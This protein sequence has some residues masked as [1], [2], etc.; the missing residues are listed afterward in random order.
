[1]HVPQKKDKACDGNLWKA[2]K[3]CINLE[4][5]MMVVSKNTLANTY[6]FLMTF[7]S[8]RKLQWYEKYHS[9]LPMIGKSKRQALSKIKDRVWQKFQEWKEK[10]LS[11]GGKEI[12]LKDVTLSIFTY[13]MSCFKLPDSLCANLERLWL[14]FSGD[15]KTM[16]EKFTRLVGKGC[17]SL[18]FM[19]ES[20]SSL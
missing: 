16:K 12:I 5:R 3:Q 4:K 18:S 7:W 20:V 19:V 15:K 8:N 1:M 13:A 14:N 10:I 11:H 17:V 2:S 6:E 9:L